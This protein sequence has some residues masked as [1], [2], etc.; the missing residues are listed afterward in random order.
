MRERSRLEQRQR[1]LER[2]VRKW[3]R[4]EEGSQTP[5][6]I[7]KYKRRRLD[8]Q[9]TLREFIREHDDVL[10][11]D[12]CREK[13]H[14]PPKSQTLQAPI[15]A[16]DVMGKDGSFSVDKA[17]QNYK[18]SL[19]FYPEEYK[20]SLQYYVEN[21]EFLPQIEIKAPFVY[22]S[23]RDAVLYD[24]THRNFWFLDFEKVITHELAHRADFLLFKSIDNTPFC[25][26]I[27]KASSELRKKNRLETVLSGC[28]EEM[29]NPCFSDI[30]SALYGEKHA[31]IRAG[32]SREYWSVPGNKE[33][34]IFAELFTLQ[35]LKEQRALQIIEKEFPEIYKAFLKIVEEVV[36]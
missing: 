29:R 13:I 34:E 1:E 20:I 18:N 5:E 17:L 31:L 32:H 30:F 21:T 9:K 33:R 19:H 22:S 3:K 7:A 2:K 14:V 26:A 15:M 25:R 16:P 36:I 11:R 27:A 8:A 28:V 6:A 24:E 23:G 12:Y 10:R 35:S 4:L